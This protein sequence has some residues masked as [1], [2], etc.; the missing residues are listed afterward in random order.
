MHAPGGENNSEGFFFDIGWS[1]G[2]SQA[3]RKR[4]V[5][6]KR[7]HFIILHDPIQCVREL[8]LCLYCCSCLM[9]KTSLQST[10]IDLRH[11]AL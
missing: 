1:C 8:E 6:E 5:V 3:R 7:E 4:D 2:V 9:R 10:A 11:V